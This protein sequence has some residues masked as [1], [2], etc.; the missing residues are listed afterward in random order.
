MQYSDPLCALC[1]YHTVMPVLKE[2]LAS[3]STANSI[4]LPLGHSP[5]DHILVYML[6]MVVR[7]SA[8]VNRERDI[9]PRQRVYGAHPF[10]CTPLGVQLSVPVLRNSII[11]LGQDT[12][13]R[14][15]TTPVIIIIVMVVVQELSWRM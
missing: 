2:S 10:L 6:I 9:F 7:T 4:P 8:R 1:G 5:I 14:Y 11:E 3:W 12:P 13:S 15:L